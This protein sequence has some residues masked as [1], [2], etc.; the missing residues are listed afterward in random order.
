MLTEPGSFATW[1]VPAQVAQLY[2]GLLFAG[3]LVAKVG[4]PRALARAIAA[5]EILPRSIAYPAAV[6]LL[7]A[8]MFI[9]FGLCTGYPFVFAAPLAMLVLMIFL[10]AT[11]IALARGR[12]VG[13]GCFGISEQ[14]ISGLTVLRQLVLIGATLLAMSVSLDRGWRAPFEPVALLGDAASASHV[15]AIFGLSL[16]FICASAWGGQAVELWRLLRNESDGS[17]PDGAVSH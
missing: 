9:A 2:V 7:A 6:L 15:V 1:L 3:A 14:K 16:F 4:S 13:C 11:V 12:N 8:E 17:A 10:G 5:Y